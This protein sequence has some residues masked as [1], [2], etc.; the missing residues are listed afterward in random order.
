M[1][2]LIAFLLALIPAVA[3]AYPLVRRVGRVSLSDD[4]TQDTELASRWET[5]IT[6]LKN[7]ELEWAIGNL[8]TEDRKWLREQYMT[9]AALVLKEMELEEGEE[10]SVIA[11]VEQEMKRIRVRAGGEASEDKE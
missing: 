8:A 9:D 3:V 4:E 1:L 11:T 6:G 10:R 5:A 7:T 2:V